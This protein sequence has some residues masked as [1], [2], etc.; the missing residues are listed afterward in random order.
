ME[1]QSV[2]CESTVREPSSV[3]CPPPKKGVEDC[4]YWCGQQLYRYYDPDLNRRVFTHCP[5][6]SGVVLGAA[7]DIDDSRSCRQQSM[8][9]LS[10]YD[11]CLDIML[12]CPYM[13]ETNGETTYKSSYRHPWI[14]AKE[15]AKDEAIA[16]YPW[17]NKAEKDDESQRRGFLSR[18][19]STEVCQETFVRPERR[20]HMPCAE[21]LAVYASSRNLR[22]PTS[23]TCLPCRPSRSRSRRG[24]SRSVSRQRPRTP[25]F[26]PCGP[27]LSM[28]GRPPVRSTSLTLQRPSPQESV[29]ILPYTDPESLTKVV[30]FRR[31]SPCLNRPASPRNSVYTTSYTDPTLH[32]FYEK[33]L[34]RRPTDGYMTPP[35]LWAYTPRRKRRNTL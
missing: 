8:T 15:V 22:I 1:R 30:R 21:D 23:S 27:R 32:P 3:V 12:P 28:P 9:D 26:G 19:G 14:V 4:C 7:R 29:H 6:Y 31:S 24:F 5:I 2:R 16:C 17:A 25:M 10:P 35:E 11:P 34:S 33:S 13:E 18:N 20:Y